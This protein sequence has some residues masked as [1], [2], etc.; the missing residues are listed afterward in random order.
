MRLVFSIFTFI[1]VTSVAP[2][3]ENLERLKVAVINQYPFVIVQ[4]GKKPDGLLVNKMTK[5]AEKAGFVVDFVPMP[6]PQR[7]LSSLEAGQVDISL[8]GAKNTDSTNKFDYVEPAF[9]KHSVVIL[10][11]NSF[12]PAGVNFF[13]DLN[14]GKVGYARGYFLGHGFEKYVEQLPAIK[15]VEV[16]EPGIALKL[17][18]KK[19][20]SSFAIDLETS[21]SK[22]QKSFTC[23]DFDFMISKVDYILSYIVLHRGARTN[24]I[25]DRLS[26]ALKEIDSNGETERINAEFWKT[27]ED[28]LCQGF[29]KL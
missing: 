26:K 25:S 17:L 23:Y 9:F 22:Q 29:K 3:P 5:L 11:H 21:G 7:L 14:N 20:I 27:H 16:L 8:G 6:S 10:T 24:E 1:F 18:Q 2:M 13:T 15:K 12:Y 4:P 19:R 28:K